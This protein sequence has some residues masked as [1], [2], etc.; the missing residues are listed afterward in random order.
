MCEATPKEGLKLVHERFSNRRGKSGGNIA[1]DRR[2]E[3]RI[4][5][6]KTLIGNLGSNFTQNNVHHVNSTLD[7]KE[8]LFLTSRESHGIRIRG[9]RHN[10]RSDKEDYDKL[11]KILTDTKADCK[12]SG[13]TFGDLIFPSDLMDHERFNR[14]QFFRWITSKNKEAKSVLAAKRKK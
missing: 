5:T 3:Y 1:R 8:E 2:M 13:R 9:G 12:I 11:F 6:A 10:P 4:G 7:I 14:A